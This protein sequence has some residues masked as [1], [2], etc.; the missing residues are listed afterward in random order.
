[1]LC[2]SLLLGTLGTINASEA[3][4]DVI[5]YFSINAKTVDGRWTTAIE[6]SETTVQRISPTALFLYEI[7]NIDTVYQP[8]I[9]IEFADNTLD[10]GDRWEICFDGGAAGGAAPTATC[11]KFVIEGH[12][13][14]K[15]YVGNGAGWTL[16]ANP[17]VSWANTIATSAHD[18]APHSILEL[19]FDKAQFSWGAN[20]PPIG[21]RIACY[22]ASNAAAGWQAWP[23]QA[24]S[25]DNPTR[26]G[27]ISG[28][29]ME[30][31]PEGLTIGAMM[32]LSAVAV[33]VSVSYFRK[34][35]IRS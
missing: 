27:L 11:N 15:T 22:D 17:V 35:K 4:Y 14:L 16:I 24:I 2:S 5:E 26:W 31:A 23:P 12:T 30:A 20:P 18:P 13:T 25:N 34:Q 10:A 21:M 33:V 8:I 7:V 19:A 6:W 32:L 9:L 1:M 29:S 3:G 28:Y